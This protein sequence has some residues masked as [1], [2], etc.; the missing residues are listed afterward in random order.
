MKFFPMDN[1]AVYALL[2]AGGSSARMG[3][4]KLCLSL[5]GK[6]PLARALEALLASKNKPAR[7]V[8]A[9]SESLFP[10]AQNLAA[11]Y[12]NVSV[13]KGGTTRGASALAGLRALH[14]TSGIALIHDAARCLASP[15]LFDAAVAGARTHGCG[16]AVIPVRDT[17]RGGA[18]EAVPREGLFA[19]QTPQAFDLA[20]ILAAYEQAEAAGLHSTDDLGVWLAAGHAAHYTQGDLMNQKLTYPEDS[21]FFSHAACGEMRIGEGW[22]T[23]RLVE[24]RALVLGGVN[25]P[26]EKGLFG[27]SDAD[28]L[29][30]A[31]IDA[32]LGAAALGDI[33][34]HFP[35][36]DARYRGI[37]SISLLKETARLIA[38]AGF[39]IL[40]VDAT[41]TAQ[42][43]RLAPH[44]EA[45]RAQ[46][47]EA[48]GCEHARV[49]VKAK[50]AEGLNDEGR[51]LCISA[52][53]VC[54]LM[55]N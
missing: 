22:D 44:I 7:I 27:H 26:F 28:A 49:N 30:H 29:T 1:C 8:I 45:M 19:V 54:A 4:D 37:C 20:M 13:T 10:L 55:R 18:G 15:M 24:G 14:A 50:T 16:V 21:A 9:A 46:L 34:R 3:Q 2:L 23:H 39:M 47:A 6:T 5:H 11:Q 12:E 17:L 43:P 51:E 41:V 48:L 36:T 38:E 53:A 31:I 42:R 32:L 40:N 33:G 25:I 52:R 35:D